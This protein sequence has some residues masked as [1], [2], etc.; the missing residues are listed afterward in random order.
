M[1]IRPTVFFCGY[2]W[3]YDV[4]YYAI[5]F[6]SS[7]L[8]ATLKS[9]RTI[10]DETYPL[11]N[12]E[13]RFLDEVFDQQYQDDRRF[14]TLFTLFTL[15]AILV[16][17][18]GLQGLATFAIEKRTKEIGIRKV[19]GATP[20]QI[21]IMLTTDFTSLVAVSFVLACPV[22]YLVMEKWLQNYAYRTGQSWLVFVVAGALALLI[23]VGTTFFQAY[24][25]AT[26][27]PITALR[28][29]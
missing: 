28:Y 18:L 15:L 20:A 14:G 2:K 9:I 21:V 29:E 25:A 11:D 10:W 12:F 26:R 27:N 24:R 17:C 16:A 6:K 1:E 8:A 22:A 19:N 4:G 5:K 3:I 7:D 23:A 13:Y